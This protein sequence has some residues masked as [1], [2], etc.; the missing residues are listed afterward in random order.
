MPFSG[1]LFR[2]AWSRPASGL[3]HAL[4]DPPL[5]V[6]GSPTMRE[7]VPAF[8]FVSSSLLF[9]DSPVTNHDSR[10]RDFLRLVP[11]YNHIR[12][13]QCVRLF[14]LFSDFRKNSSRSFTPRATPSAASSSFAIFP[15]AI[16]PF[17]LASP[18]LCAPMCPSAPLSESAC[19]PRR[20]LTSEYVGRGRAL[21]GVVRSRFGTLTTF[22]GISRR[23]LPVPSMSAPRH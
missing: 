3:E 1:A 5:L 8:H 10:P 19:V 22:P 14:S 9:H 12:A 4:A 21:G 23:A 7:G 20:S 2:V 15:F 17:S 16:W 11:A 6:V 18:R 13:H